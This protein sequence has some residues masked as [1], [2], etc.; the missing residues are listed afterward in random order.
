MKPLVGALMLVLAGM[1]GARGTV[2]LAG[3]SPRSPS[4]AP[5]PMCG[6]GLIESGEACD[7]GNGRDGDG[8]SARCVI[9]DQCYDRGTAFSFFTWS[10]SYTTSGDAAVV[11][12]FRDAVDATH[13][14]R[15]VIPRFWI[16]VGDIPFMADGRHRLDELNGEL[17]GVI[18]CSA[19][20]GGYPYFVALG[21]HDVDGY[22]PTTPHSQY[23]YWSTVVGGRIDSTLVG[24]R[25]IQ[26]GPAGDHDR[27]TT[28][29]F[30]YKNAHFVI[31]NQYHGD[32]MY[33]TAE[34]SGC[35]RPALHD[36]IDAD[37]SRTTGS[38]KFV[39]G[40]EPAW[41]YCS[42]GEGHGGELCPVG[43]RDHQH[44]AHRPRPHSATG[45]WP[46]AFGRHWGDSLEDTAC[47]EGSRDAFW[48]ML[49][50]HNVIAHYV[51]HTHAYSSRLI[52]G[53]GTPRDDVSAYAKT[54]TLFESRE[55]V[56][57]IDNG[58]AHNV[59]GASYVLTTVR[60]DVVTFEAYDQ[61]GPE[62][63]F[64]LIERWSVRVDRPAVDVTAESGRAVRSEAP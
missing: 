57:E 62:E 36:W 26:W 56:W 8:C 50:R 32:P 1:V 38:I 51:G 52:R 27:R 60:D 30:D 61:I 20:P 6:N 64:R 18:R 19:S 39:F 10:D 31:V 5:A 35:I 12:I 13:Y 21:N 2:A 7:D 43:H 45:S 9:E 46:V 63:P 47:P 34:P 24:I 59:A 33:P 3:S 29:S 54:G 42:S 25:N 22:H 37:L 55:G 53:D 48:A 44:P 4:G 14:S 40:H 41:S 15:R 16:A 23:E 49:A 28:Y 58:Q 17:A 11:R